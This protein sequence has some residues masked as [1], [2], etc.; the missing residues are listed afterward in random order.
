[1]RKVSKSVRI[2]RRLYRRARALGR[3]VPV[4]KLVALMAT[5][6]EDWVL[7]LSLR[8]SLSYCDAVIMTDHGSTDRTAQIVRDAQAEFPNCPI[9]VRRVENGE[10]REGDFRQEMLERGRRL[11]ATHFVIVDAD[12]VP[13]GNLLLQLRSLALRAD[14]GWCAA[15]PM[16]APYHSSTM[17]RWDG[18][19]GEQSAIPWA[20]GDSAELNWKSSSAYQLHRRSPNGAD[21]QGLLVSGKERGGLFHLQF[22]NKRRLQSKAAWYKMMETVTYPGKRTAADL[23]QMYD[24]TLR[25]ESTAKIDVMPQA[26]WTPYEER[27]WLQ[28][29][30]PDARA[31][32]F[33]EARKLAAEHGLERFS[34][35]ELYGII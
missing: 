17:Y 2:I 26:W 22:I 31:W 24:W 8:V 9:D 29:L 34:G 27:G 23:N 15:L 18:P 6:N 13:T 19:W 25:E 28:F 5:R 3:P 14:P 7:G 10:W 11:G 4:P 35:L 21:D 20:F 1:M 33:H 16:I 32:Q 30:Q 12:E